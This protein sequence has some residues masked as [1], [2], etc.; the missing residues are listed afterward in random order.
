MYNQYTSANTPYKRKKA[1]RDIAVAELL[2]S[3]GMQISELCNL[4][5]SDINLNDNIVLI[6]YIAADF[7]MNLLNP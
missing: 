1:F 7:L 4:S 3:T 2:F 5:P 6:Q